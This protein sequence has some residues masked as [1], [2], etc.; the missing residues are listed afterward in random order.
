MDVVLHD[1]ATLA[2]L[3]RL[4][5]GAQLVGGAMPA[6]M[7]GVVLRSASGA[8]RLV[9][10]EREAKTALGALF[11]RSLRPPAA[12]GAAPE[13]LSACFV[14]RGLLTLHPR[15][16]L[17]LWQVPLMIVSL[18]ISVRHVDADVTDIRFYPGALI[19][20]GRY[21]TV[22]VYDINT[23]APLTRVLTH[24]NSVSRGAAAAAAVFAADASG[25]VSQ[26]D[27]K[28]SCP[29]NPRRD[30][31]SAAAAVAVAEADAAAVAVAEAEAEAEAEAAVDKRGAVVKRA[32]RRSTLKRRTT[33]I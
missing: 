27:P 30:A 12:C 16:T 8:G 26:L 23:L 2:P 32:V 31:M 1:L 10:V 25:V 3:R 5:S 13:L 33:G 28:P 20:L 19:G 15:G 11:S 7:A 14:P 9:S 21:G 4:A 18:P 17:L 22:Y 29:K 24:V 6:G